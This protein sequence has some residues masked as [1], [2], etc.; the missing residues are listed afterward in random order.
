MRDKFGI[1]W[2]DNRCSKADF[3]ANEIT[4]RGCSRFYCANAANCGQARDRSCP[5]K[6]MMDILRAYAD[7]GYT[8]EEIADLGP[9]ITNAMETYRALGDADHLREL[10]DAEKDGRLVVLP[11]TSNAARKT[12]AARYKEKLSIIS[13]VVAALAADSD[14]TSI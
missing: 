12:S 3:F 13:A 2:R 7:V 9:L 14:S 4:K 11:K 1:E 5:I 8:P 6:E 10:V